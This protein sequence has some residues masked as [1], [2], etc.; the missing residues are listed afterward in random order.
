[1]AARSPACKADLAPARPGPARALHGTA[2]HGG[3]T[4]TERD[5]PGRS[6]TAR[7]TQIAAGPCFPSPVSCVQAEPVAGD[8]VFHRQA[9]PGRAGPQGLDPGRMNFNSRYHRGQ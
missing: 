7:L 8:T 9:A 5:I 4:V 1:M 2:R 6:P 3:S